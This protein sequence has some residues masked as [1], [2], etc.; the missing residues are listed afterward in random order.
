LLSQRRER[1]RHHRTAGKRYE[2]A[3]SHFVALKAERQLTYYSN[4]H[5][6]VQY[7]IMR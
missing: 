6:S 2:L 5:W 4:P 1:Q 3:P 7:S